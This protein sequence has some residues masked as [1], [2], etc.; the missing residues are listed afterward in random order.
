MEQSLIITCNGQDIFTSHSKWLYPL[1]ELEDFLKNNNFDLKK[2]LLTD[3]IAGKA[4][5]FLITRLG[6]TNVHIHL[7]SDGAVKVFQRFGIKFTYDE[8]VT[9]I[10]CKTEEIVSGSETLDEVWQMLRRRAG[11]V[12]G[13]TVNISDLNVK[14]NNEI[15]L[16]NLNLMIGKGEHVFIKGP[17]GSGKTTL[18]KTILGLQSSDSGTIHI[19]DFKVGD[20]EWKKNRFVTGYVPQ[21]M[22]KNSFPVSASEVVEIAFA[23]QKISRAEI[24]IRVE[25]AMRRTACFHLAKRPFND[26]SGGEKQRVSIARCLCQQ[27]RLLLLDEPTSFLDNKSKDDLFELLNEIW[28]N[29][30]PTAIIVSHDYQWIERFGWPVYELVDKKIC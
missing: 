22:I 13:L 27:A 11:R 12:A 7:I 5:A 23:S 3:K 4:A 26:L 21:E 6:F 19:G 20:K 17:N 25:I 8:I 16:E 28:A 30:A 15:I 24:D 9:K 10:Q 29:E 14:I 2:L 1:F 18:L